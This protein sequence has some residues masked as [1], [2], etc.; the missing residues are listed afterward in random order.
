[1]FEHFQIELDE[2][3]RADEECVVTEV[4]DG[5]R[6][7]GSDSEVRN[8]RFHAWTFRNGKVIRL[9]S[10]SDRVR[11]LEACGLSE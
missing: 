11:A 8:H 4:H 7:P 3:I 5:G 10:H 2:V 9:S 1:M 6:L